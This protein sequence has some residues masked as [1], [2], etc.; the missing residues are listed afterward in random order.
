MT[1][2]MAPRYFTPEQN[3]AVEQALKA[4]NIGDDEGVRIFII[5]LEYELAE[6]ENL[7]SARQPEQQVPDSPAP[8]I[9][10][11]SQELATVA[12]QLG[13]LPEAGRLWLL[14]GLTRQDPFA[15]VHDQAYLDAVV[16]ELM[17]I[18]SVCAAGQRP[19][20]TENGLGD[21]EKHFIGVIAEAYYECFEARPCDS[22][23]EPFTTLLQRIFEISGLHIRLNKGEL[24]Q[25]LASI[26]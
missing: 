25:I 13:Q 1:R 4:L 10:Q 20:P 2:F 16:A 8:P 19:V 22:G 9:E 11:L 14:N 26:G 3:G 6:Y 7:G 17:R 5:A 21:A 12:S 23:G 24:D 18:A 15:R